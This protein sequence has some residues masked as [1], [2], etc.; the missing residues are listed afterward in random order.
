MWSKSEF[1]WL[2]IRGREVEVSFSPNGKYLAS[3]WNHHKLMIWDIE[4]PW[5][6]KQLCAPISQLITQNLQFRLKFS[7]PMSTLFCIAKENRTWDQTGTRF[8]G[9]YSNLVYEI[10]WINSFR[11]IS[12]NTTFRC[13]L[14][15]DVNFFKISRWNV[16]LSYKNPRCIYCWRGKSQFWWKIFLHFKIL[17]HQGKFLLD[18]I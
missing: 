4:V 3:Y 7:G 16:K 8:H 18:K 14:I 17:Q 10:I 15:R 2:E 6:V 12:L 9:R 11:A 5:N 1:S 13:W